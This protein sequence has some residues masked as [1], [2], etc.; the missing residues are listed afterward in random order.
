[1][2]SASPGTSVKKPD[3]NIKSTYTVSGAGFSP[4]PEPYAGVQVSDEDPGKL[5][6]FSFL[7]KGHLLPPLPQRESL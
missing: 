7:K 3:P 2:P 6:L 5:G 4:R 1:V